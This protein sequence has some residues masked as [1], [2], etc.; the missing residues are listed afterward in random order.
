MRTVKFLALVLGLAVFTF[1]SNRYRD[2]F[3]E[4]HSFSKFHKHGEK[5]TLEKKS[6]DGNIGNFVDSGE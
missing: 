6:M 5:T 1:L 2:N 3:T 4:A